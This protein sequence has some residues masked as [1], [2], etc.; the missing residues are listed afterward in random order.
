VAEE[1]EKTI[2]LEE[3][4]DLAVAVVGVVLAGLEMLED[5]P[6]WKAM[7]VVLDRVLQIGPQEEGEVL[8]LLVVRQQAVALT[9]GQVGQEQLIQLQVVRSLMLLAVVDV[10]VRLG[11]VRLLVMLLLVLGLQVRPEIPQ[12]Q[13]K[14]EEEE[15]H[16]RL[17]VMVAMA[18]LV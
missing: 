13:I 9:M 3:T 16:P 2:P 8:L 6:Q 15:E 17:L 10:L 1:G 4:E 18:V 11:L 5:F 12:M 14:V 7:Q